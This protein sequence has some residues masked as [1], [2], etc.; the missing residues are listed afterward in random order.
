MPPVIVHHLTIAQKFDQF[1]KLFE[2][3]SIEMALGHFLHKPVDKRYELSTSPD[4]KK[5]TVHI[6]FSDES[7]LS[8][9]ERVH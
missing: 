8:L 2:P 3:R 5:Q 7:R 6:I 4:A 9:T 1:Q